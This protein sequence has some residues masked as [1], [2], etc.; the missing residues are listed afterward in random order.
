[1]AQSRSPPVHLPLIVLLHR[2][3]YFEV[4]RKHYGIS[5]LGLLTAIAIFFS[6]NNLYAQCEDGSLVG[7]IHDGTGAAVPGAIAT[8]TNSATGLVSKATTNGEGDYEFPALKGG[9]LHHLRECDRFRR[10]SCQEHQRFGGLSR[11]HRFDR[12]GRIYTKF[13]RGLRRG[14]SI[15]NRLQRA[16]SNDHRISDCG[17]ALGEPEQLRPAGTGDRFTPG[18]DGRYDELD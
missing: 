18:A 10:R 16:R 2:D 3:G 15:G 6:S 8:T 7:P 11:A 9:R 1:V 5:L 14:A 17:A 13:S 4:M 12:S